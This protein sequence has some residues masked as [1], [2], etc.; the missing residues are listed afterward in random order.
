M[1]YMNRKKYFCLLIAL[2]L[3]SSGNLFAQ[4]APPTP[5]TV[6][7]PLKNVKIQAR[8]VLDENGIYHYY[9]AVTNPTEN[10]IG[11]HKVALDITVP[12]YGVTPD[13]VSKD[14]Y[15]EP[16]SD[17]Y[18]NAQRRGLLFVPIAWKNTNLWNGGISIE[19]KRWSLIG[20]AVVNNWRAEYNFSTK[21]QYLLNPGQTSEELEM[22]SYGLPGIRKVVFKSF[23]L[24][25]N[26]PTDFFL[27]EE[28]DDQAYIINSRRKESFGC[29][30]TTIGP[31]APPAFTPLQINQM[32]QEYVSQCVTLG[33]L[34]DA[35]LTQQLNNYLIQSA[36]AIKE[37][38]LTDAQKIITQFMNA[39]QNS[40]LSQRTTEAQGLLYYNARYFSGQM[41]QAKASPT[42][43]IAPN[44]GEHFLNEAHVTMV[45]VRQGDQPVS[46]F[47]LTALV[48]A[49]PHSGLVWR[50]KT[51]QGG[52]WSFSY[53]GTKLGTDTICFVKEVAA[54]ISS[55]VILWQ[56]DIMSESMPIL[57]TWTG[58]ADLM[59]NE[60]FPPMIAIPFARPTIPLEEST[61]N[62]GDIAAPASVTRCYLTKGQQP[63]PDDIVILER[64]V[65]P[66]EANAISKYQAAVPVPKNLKPGIHYIYCCADANKEIIELDEM[67]N[68][69]T[70]IVQG[71]IPVA[72]PGS[73]H[74]EDAVKRAPADRDSPSGNRPPDCSKAYAVPDT[75]R[76]PDRQWRKVFIS[77]VTDP[78]GDQ[79][80]VMLRPYIRQDEPAK[81]LE[82]DDLS[83]DVKII[84][85]FENFLELR[86][87]RSGTANGRVYH[88]GFTA[89]D[90]KGG[91]CEG[92]VKVCVPHDQ[93]QQKTCVDDGPLYDSLKP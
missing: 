34:K 72:P 26:L 91:S 73:R 49:G 24:K 16:G 79:V 85:R 27:N 47:P 80:R 67:N 56:P 75:L 74:Q 40:N 84:S 37:N 3:L 59:L 43:E 36:T 5:K 45:K 92:V 65:P 25:L 32:L 76:P 8:V 69:E 1:A 66:L 23:W 61:I 18:A 6:P 64:C 83:P 4:K 30:A 50:G 51:D 87:E 10:K 86:A 44:R 68:C 57:V 46:N 81:G 77:G 13:Y 22:I 12:N 21:Y 82:T 14:G 93:G 71:S 41:K 38:R 78:D 90:D 63:S 9:H 88:I 2:F 89:Q 20:N 35:T 60:F 15:T 39:L 62:T 7:P 17:T 48:T 58:G 53:K 70:G 54:V 31:T 42:V 11:I 52:N 29:I 33:W 55:D 19:D 28:E